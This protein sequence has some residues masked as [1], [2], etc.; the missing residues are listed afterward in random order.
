MGTI[1]HALLAKHRTNVGGY[2]AAWMDPDGKFHP[3]A[4]HSDL[5]TDVAWGYG[6]YHFGWVRIFLIPSLRELGFDTNGEVR[7]NSD[8]RAALFMLCQNFHPDRITTRNQMRDITH[9]D[10]VEDVLRE[11]IEED[12]S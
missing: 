4:C 11:V 1:P 7:I 12:Q 3:V 9:E 10:D 6:H 8:Q 5:D 2:H